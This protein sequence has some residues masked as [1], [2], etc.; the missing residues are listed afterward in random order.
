MELKDLS[1]IEEFAGKNGYIEE[2][3]QIDIIL[4]D[5]MVINTTKI[6]LDDE[7]ASLNQSISLFDD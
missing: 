3:N 2:N 6:P 5:P 1:K 4:N 7:E